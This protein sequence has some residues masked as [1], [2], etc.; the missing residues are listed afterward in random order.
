MKK[1]QCQHRVSVTCTS[2][3]Y[4]GNPSTSSKN[5]LSSASF[6]LLVLLI[7]AIPVC[8]SVAIQQ[9]RASTD[10]DQLINQLE[11]TCSSY[12]SKDLSFRTPNILGEFCALV[13]FQKSKDLKPPNNPAKRFLF[14]YAKQQGVGITEGEVGLLKV[15]KTCL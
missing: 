1:S 6:T 5:P 4:T 2:A 10:Q 7:S 9:Q 8:K 11:D 14:H 3:S 12:L 15:K 13:L